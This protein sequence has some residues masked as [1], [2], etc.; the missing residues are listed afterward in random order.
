MASKEFEQIKEL[1][2][3]SRQEEDIMVRNRE[4]EEKRKYDA[5]VEVI[6]K[7]IKED[8]LILEKSGIKS[9]FEEIRD[10]GLVKYNNES[11]YKE[12]PIYKQKIFGGKILDHY[13]NRKI[14]DYTP[15]HIYQSDP[16]SGLQNILH[17]DYKDGV[18]NISLV[19]DYSEQK[20]GDLGPDTY[21]SEIMVAVVNNK[22]NLVDDGEKH[23]SSYH[24]TPIEDG[25]LLETIAKAIKNPPI[26]E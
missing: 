14:K 15:A 21:Y 2:D 13:E 9:L 17:T 11:V 8:E 19:F 24:Y 25:K 1:V 7:K 10:S 26:Q 3:L 12:V 5:K 16:K 23:G 20:R 6:L 18:V 22:L 4:L